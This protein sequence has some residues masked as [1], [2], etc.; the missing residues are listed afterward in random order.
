[1]AAEGRNLLEVVLNTDIAKK[2][3]EVDKAVDTIQES[4][5]SAT[6]S[7]KQFAEALEGINKSF[8][9]KSGF[10]SFAE[11]IQKLIESLNGLN[12]NTGA[13]GI[14]Q[15]TKEISNLGDVSK[16]NIDLVN[17]LVEA[18]NKIGTVSPTTD[19]AG[20]ATEKAQ[21]TLKQLKDEIDTL[22][23]KLFK[24]GVSKE[25][26][27]A[28]VDQLAVLK[29]IVNLRKESTQEKK[30]K[31]DAE[32]EKAEAK[33]LKEK[34]EAEKAYIKHLKEE[35]DAKALRFKDSQDAYKQE[36]KALQEQAKEEERIREDANKRRRAEIRQAFAEQDALEKQE[37]E[38]RKSAEKKISSL[39]EQRMKLQEKQNKVQLKYTQEE[40][41]KNRAS[42]LSKLQSEY[43]SLGR[44]IEG[45]NKRLEA[46][47]G[48]YK[49]LVMKGEH[50]F[51]D[52][53]LEQQIRYLEQYD[54]LML[55]IKETKA[56]E[57][58]AKAEQDEANALKRYIELAKEKESLLKNISVVNNRQ[59][60]GIITPEETSLLNAAYSYLGNI[61]NEMKSLEQS[62]LKVQEYESEYVK[63][64]KQQ[65]DIA[66]L[67]VQNEQD[68]RKAREE[69]A[70]QEQKNAKTA[71]DELNLLEQQIKARQDI[72]RAQNETYSGAINY[73][74]RAKNIEQEKQA[75]E[76]LKAARDKLNYSDKDYESKLSQLNQRIRQHE[77]NIKRA[78]GAT[79]QFRQENIKLNNVLQQVAGAFGVYLSVQGLVN[80]ARIVATTT[81]EFELQH[82]ALQAII[83]DIDQA[84]KLWDKTVRLAVRSPFSVKELAT[85]TKQLA[86]Y[87]VE[88]EKLYDT[89]KMLADISAG[90]GVDMN[91]LILAYGQVKAANYLRGQELRQFSEAGI[92]ILGELAKYFEEI[93]GQAVSTGDVFEM[94]SKRMVKFK[95]VA[96]VL[97]RLT[98]EGGI[99]FNMQEIQAETIKGQLMNLRDSVDLF[100]NSIG[101][102]RKGIIIGAIKGIRN[103]LE[104]IQSIIPAIDAAL[105]VMATR[106]VA[107]R[108]HSAIMAITTG[109]W[110]SMFGNNLTV[111]IGKMV[112]MNIQQKIRNADMAKTIALGKRLSV[113]EDEVARAAAAGGTKFGGWATIISTVLMVVIAIVAK[114]TEFNRKMKRLS[115]EV[116]GTVDEI[117]GRLPEK[118]KTYDMLSQKINLLNK[119]SKER[120][121]IIGKINSQYG[122]FLDFQVTDATTQE[123]L[124]KAYDKVNERM[125]E[126]A[127]LEA[128]QQGLEKIHQT[129]DKE[130]SDDENKLVDKL[131]ELGMRI[132][133]ED[134]TFSN[135]SVQKKDAKVLVQLLKEMA[136]EIPTEEWDDAGERA[137]KFNEI[138]SEY[139]GSDNISFLGIEK[140]LNNFLDNYN[141]FAKKVTELQDTIDA[142]FNRETKSRAANK[143]L[144]DLQHE[145]D[146]T[147]KKLQETPKDDLLKPIAEAIDEIKRKF[148]KDRIDIKI[149]FGIISEEAGQEEKDKIDNWESSLVKSINEQWEKHRGEF[150]PDLFYD[151]FIDKDEQNAGMSEFEKSIQSMYDSAKEGEEQLLRYKNQGLAVDED[152]L[153]N[154]QER[155]R[156][157]ET[158]AEILG[159]TL[160]KEKNRTKNEKQLILLT[161]KQVDVLK[162]AAE[163]YSQLKDEMG[164]EI[165]PFSD[166]FK[167]FRENIEA[168]FKKINLGDL[169][170]KNWPEIREV[171]E[172]QVKAAE[173]IV[174]RFS[175][176]GQQVVSTT[177]K[178]A[179]DAIL[180]ANEFIGPF[181]AVIKKLEEH[182]TNTSLELLNKQIEAIKNAAKQYDEYK[183][184]YDD[185][186]AFNKTKT[187]VSGL[188]KELNIGHILKK[189]GA[190]D[191]NVIKDN[192]E[193]WLASSIAAAGK[194]GRQVAQKYI[195]GLQL[196]FEKEEYAKNIVE[197]FKENLDDAFDELSLAEE[198]SKLGIGRDFAKT[199]FG[200]DTQSTEEIR[201]F[202][203]NWKSQLQGRGEYGETAEKEYKSAIEKIDDMEDK[204]QKERLKKYIDYTKQAMTE[205]AK[206]EV[207][208]LREL[209]DIEKAFQIEIAKAQ[210][211]GDTARENQLKGIM[212]TAIE[213]SKKATEEKLGKQ[214]WEDFKGSELYI[215][216]FDDL[217]N[218]TTKVIETI[219]EK[220][221][222]L[223]ES[224]KGL[225]PTDLKSITQE[226]NKLEDELIKRNPFKGFIDSWKKVKELQKEGKTEERLSERLIGNQEDI[227]MYENLI[228]VNEKLLEVRSKWSQEQIDEKG[229]TAAFL[230]QNN[231]LQSQ[232]N[233]WKQLI[234]QKK[235]DS[236]IT[237]AD[238]ET[239]EQFQKAAKSYADYL[240]NM[241]SRVA[242]VFSDIMNNLE[243]FGGTTTETTK[244]WGDMGEAIM[245]I[246]AM[247]PGYILLM[248]AAGVA[249]KT[250]F[251]PIGWIMMAVEA[252]V[253]IIKGIA[254]LRNAAIDDEIERYK[255]QVDELSDKYDRLEKKFDSVWDIDKLRAYNTEMK[256]NMEQQIGYYEKMIKAEQS[257]KSPDQ[258]A[259]DEYNKQINDLYDQMEDRHDEWLEKVS[260]FGGESS[261]GDA[262]QGFIDAWYDAFAETGDGLEG[263][264]ENFNEIIENMVKKQAAS[265]LA[266]AILEPLYKKINQ[267]AEDG[268]IT[269]SE[270]DAIVAEANAT[271]PELNEKLKAFFQSLGVFGEQAKGELDG[272]QKG[273]QGVTE[274]TAEII[275]AYMNA[276]RYYVIDNN[277]KLGQ[278][279]SALQD[280]TGTFNPMVAE[281]RNIR[282]QAEDIRDLLFSWRETGGVPSMRVTIV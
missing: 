39:F 113:V 195:S 228:V 274:Q 229:G 155:K 162:S 266:N 268:T 133:N 59:N 189:G 264:R 224:Y 100:M 232:I 182:P 146:E 275:A 55:K 194:G 177:M 121:D 161:E 128:Y 47:K 86:A 214:A 4:M 56:S 126:K 158:M 209:A 261:W 208:G 89:T 79:E 179:A 73:S 282:Q 136:E 18:L 244:A 49:G 12:A 36:T 137:K 3:N 9:D 48:Q 234:Q 180:S 82:R 253:A 143:A 246:A 1:M 70:K 147:I 207:E 254:N 153:A 239:Y 69:A 76:Y 68:L 45:V 129:F 281:L 257:R 132:Q 109:K 127:A 46:M 52:K 176:E 106:F 215:E 42:E 124:A 249:A 240:Q 60:A 218:V 96:E 245:S 92:N 197:K 212:E 219:Q 188:F 279:I 151:M 203:E 117:A 204:A 164:G 78:T 273:I 87:R 122:E 58:G 221:Q 159:M 119:G 35:Q 134:G 142:S 238:L 206:I 13:K 217:G 17:K 22:E 156:A 114:L 172:N 277:T 263:L 171:W 88:T 95:D 185:T 105:V 150:D 34:A 168:E 6:E 26:E 258:S 167:V 251:G 7:A 2:F 199:L 75:I 29:E 67:I 99:F 98:Q 61:T 112:A 85:Y 115:E 216:M 231:L 102:R 236:T 94:V 63:S 243:A 149:R 152:L 15:T 270:I 65:L 262:T 256:R 252:L 211:A 260:G 31:E 62:S 193:K 28:L 278:I 111:L 276:I 123:E 157:A 160:E 81:G 192:L 118:M 74:Q 53:E 51:A 235:K 64:G 141:E 271:F 71:E 110:V 27:Q 213:G 191:E 186:T 116:R 183:K 130:F 57:A 41:T 227:E 154:Y 173:D 25:E 10:A 104:D 30:K 140:Y 242:A 72:A 174:K 90:L 269:N 44:S 125:K 8:G 43:D 225:N 272:L 210:S 241:G 14:E 220:I 83:G 148:E 11:N 187:E 255:E 170:E 107:I 32:A 91:R 205:R 93:K 190:F 80:F 198:L 19:L 50:A 21:L 178:A 259:I 223:K 138:I 196:E 97:K 120:S 103:A 40:N 54:A 280:S 33:A 145:Y 108:A 163:Q 181:L 248:E 230:A 131:V 101:E 24:K 247:I 201:K 233:K 166:R 23:D 184:M 37:I 139:Y 250:A 200:I 20:F 237:S 222:Q 175:I 135:F 267:A 202:V 66:R 84:N 226:I 5:K 16:S 265:R 144:K 169:L 38:N 165:D 77:E